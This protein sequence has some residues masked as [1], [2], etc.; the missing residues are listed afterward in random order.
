LHPC[1]VNDDE[2]EAELK[3][4]LARESE[5]RGVFFDEKT[6]GKK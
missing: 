6:E 5:V 3:K 4:T 1:G 2:F